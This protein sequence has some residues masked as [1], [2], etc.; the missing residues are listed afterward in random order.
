V[1]KNKVVILGAG[2]TGLSA[3]SVLGNHATVLEK[4]DRPGGLVKAENFNGYWFDHVLHLL[5]FQQMTPVEERIKELAGEDLHPIYPEA[6]VETKEGNCRYPLQM[7]LSGL[8]TEAIIRVLKDLALATFTDD[9]SQPKNFKDMLIRSFGEAFCELFML[10]YNN[11]V[12]KRPLESLAPSGFQWNIDHP[13]FTQVL[14]GSLSDHTEFKSYNS[15]GWYP[16]PPKSSS[17]RGMEVV[18][19][20]LAEKLKHLNLEHEVTKIDLDSRIITS[21]YKGEESD[22]HFSDYCL[23][24]I[25]LPILLDR[26]INLPEHLHDKKDLLKCN[27]VISVMLSI[28]GPRPEN[29]GHWRYYPQEELSFTRLVYMHNFDPDTAPADGWGLMTE[30]IEPSEWPLKNKEEIF[31]KT[32]SDV[33]ASSALPDDCEII[34]INMVVVNPAYVVFTNESKK[35][36]EELKT[37]YDS[38]GLKLLGRY[39]QWEYSSM[40]QVMRDG[41]AWAEEALEA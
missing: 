37:Y 18:S 23:S 12:W 27:R 33:K 41:F 35:Y 17:V 14:R 2:L 29:R 5:H 9:K 3:A 19:V 25:P 8:N 22:F 4:T 16:R 6:W 39:G 26:T 10:P 32:V 24:T 28:K 38:K 36:V 15:N 7:H 30:I 31:A 1:K 21:I 11:K 40:A 34:D 13:D 20:R